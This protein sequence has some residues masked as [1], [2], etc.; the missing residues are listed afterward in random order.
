MVAINRNHVIVTMPLI[1]R[2]SVGL[3]DPNTIRNSREGGVVVPQQPIAPLVVIP[4]PNSL[5][6]LS[7]EVS[8]IPNDAI[9]TELLF[10]AT[11]A[12]GCWAMGVVV[13]LF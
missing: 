12:V 13:Y 2:L 3:L 6:Y 8:T 7:G 5:P 9:A 1:L 4:A 10:A 11:A